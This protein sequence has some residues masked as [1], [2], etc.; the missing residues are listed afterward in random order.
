MTDPGAGNNIIL[1]KKQNNAG[2]LKLTA[3]CEMRKADVKNLCPH[4]FL[5][6]SKIW[7]EKVSKFL[8]M[9]QRLF[10]H[11]LPKDGNVITCYSSNSR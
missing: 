3:N 9:E 6:V 8:P 10:T 11:L 1:K 5:L 2:C 7:G 4:F